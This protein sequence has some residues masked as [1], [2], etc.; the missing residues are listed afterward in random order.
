MKLKQ[1]LSKNLW[2]MHAQNFAWKREEVEVLYSNKREDGIVHEHVPSLPLLTTLLHQM[3]WHRYVI[4]KSEVI[5]DWLQ[6]TVMCKNIYMW[7]YL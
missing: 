5:C 4:G 6:N 7:K 2:Q 3:L 1:R